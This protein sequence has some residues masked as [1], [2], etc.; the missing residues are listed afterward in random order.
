[1]H[2]GKLTRD[3]NERRLSFLSQILSNLLGN[4]CERLRFDVGRLQLIAR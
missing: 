2:E 4:E 1:M 3:Y